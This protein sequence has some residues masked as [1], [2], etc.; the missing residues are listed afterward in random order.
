MRLS[1]VSHLGPS[2][3]RGR[4]GDSWR[5]GRWRGPSCLDA[6]SSNVVGSLKMREPQGAAV[7]WIVSSPRVY[8]RV[9][10]QM[11]FSMGRDAKQSG[12]KWLERNLKQRGV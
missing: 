3:R 8:C 12:S 4:Q 6:V 10:L 9:Y 11:G 1:M 2:R 5:R 7:A